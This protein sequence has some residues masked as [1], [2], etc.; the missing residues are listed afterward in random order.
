MMP[1]PEVRARMARLRARVKDHDI[2]WWLRSF[3]G[4]F[5][6]PQ[7]YAAAADDEADHP[8]AGPERHTGLS[9]H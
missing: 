9:R 1:L 3:L 5:P 8:T 4:E 2:Q 6:L 7:T